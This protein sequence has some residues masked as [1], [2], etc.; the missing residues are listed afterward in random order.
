MLATATGR[1]HLQAGD[2]HAPRDTLT[3]ALDQLPPIARR[4]RV[5]VMLDSPPPNSAPGASGACRH[6]TT[7]AN[8]LDRGPGAMGAARF[9]KFRD[10]AAGQAGPKT[11]QVLDEYRSRAAA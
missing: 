11:L 10:A 2:P 9:R 1:A 4:I 8:M 7:A 3:A 6:A 5:L